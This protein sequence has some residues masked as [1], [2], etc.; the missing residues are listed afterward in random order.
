VNYNIF[1]ANYNIFGANYNIFGAN[2]NKK[3]LLLSMDFCHNE[4]A[5]KG[6]NCDEN[7]RKKRNT[8]QPFGD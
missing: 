5:R 8:E 6:G 1:G 7:F 2:Y 3:I 4:E